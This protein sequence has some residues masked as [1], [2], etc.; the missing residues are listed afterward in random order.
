M[1]EARKSELLALAILAATVAEWLWN[2]SDG[3]MTAGSVVTRSVV[4][5][6]LA[7]QWRLDR[8]RDQ[9][10]TD[11]WFTLAVMVLWVL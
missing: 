3:T 6:M 4:A 9:G 2:Y 7:A 11:E 8:P 10:L 5:L 1:T